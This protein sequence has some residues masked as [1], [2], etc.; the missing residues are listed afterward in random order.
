MS[1]SAVGSADTQ[2]TA[3]TR[4]K[5]R[6]QDLSPRKASGVCAGE[7]GAEIALFK[8]FRTLRPGFAT[9]EPL[10]SKEVLRYAAQ[11]SDLQPLFVRRGDLDSGPTVMRRCSVVQCQ[12]TKIPDFRGFFL[13]QS[14]LTDSNRRPPPYHGGFAL[15]EGTE[16]QRLF[17]GFPCYGRT[18]SAGRTPPSESPERP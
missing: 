1:F 3:P 2:V 12:A 6:P 5:W 8:R 4:S 9:G 10:P 11:Q 16:E 14:P 18:S 15:R 7:P 13:Y 17:A